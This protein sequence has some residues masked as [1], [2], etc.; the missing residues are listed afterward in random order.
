MYCPK[1]GVEYRDG[2]TECAD[3]RV[4]LLEGAPPL[5][6]PS[7]FDPA[8]DPVLALSTNDP[9]QFAMA[10]GLLDDAGIP[11]VVLGQIATLV[12]DVDPYLH[13]HVEILVPRDQEEAVRDLL[14][15]LL[16][17]EEIPESD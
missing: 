3:C 1:C 4:P 5:E 14:K 9:V 10:K 6:P 8:L 16:E 13:K 11:F 15:P 12:T 17:P 2:F 7:R